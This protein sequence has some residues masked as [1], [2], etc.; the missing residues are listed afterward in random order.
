MELA[1]KGNL[2]YSR[3][4]VPISYFSYSL[5]NLHQDN[6]ELVLLRETLSV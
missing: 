6:I 3:F 4:A 1:A 5:K 2:I